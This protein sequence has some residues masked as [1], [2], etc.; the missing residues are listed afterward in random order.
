MTRRTWMTAGAPAL[1]LMI[2]GGVWAGL[3]FANARPAETGDCCVDP[4]CP[5][6]CCP[7][8][9][10]DCTAPTAAKCET[11]GGQVPCCEDPPCP[12]CVPSS[13]AAT[14]KSVTCCPPCPFCP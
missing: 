2:A 11:T 3:A 7:E 14:S 8:C 12:I 5:P 9:P 4:T 10:P 1:A 6:G 13:R